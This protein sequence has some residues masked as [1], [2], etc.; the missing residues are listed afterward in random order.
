MA[1]RALMNGKLKNSGSGALSNNINIS[2]AKRSRN[3]GSRKELRNRESIV[4]ASKAS[5]Q[6]MTAGAAKMLLR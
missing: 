5:T 1:L 4:R 3:S 6:V 2:T